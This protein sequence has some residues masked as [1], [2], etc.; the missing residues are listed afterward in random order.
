MKSFRRKVRSDAHHR[1]LQ[2]REGSHDLP[3]LKQ[4]STRRLQRTNL[5]DPLHFFFILFALSILTSHVSTALIV[6]PPSGASDF[7]Q[8]A[9]LVVST[10]DAPIDP[11]SKLEVMQWNLYERSLSEQF[12]FKQ[13]TDTVRKMFGKKYALFVAKEYIPGNEDNG[14][15]SSYD[16]VGMIEMGMA[17][18]PVNLRNYENRQSERDEDSQREIDL[19]EAQNDN[20]V[21]KNEALESTILESDKASTTAISIQQIGLRPRATVG[22]ICVKSTN[23]NKGIGKALLGKCEEIASDV[24]NE[25][26]LFV[27]VEPD[28]KN[29]LRFFERDGYSGFEDEGGVQM[30]NATVIRKRKATSRPHLVLGKTF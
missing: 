8:L 27:E 9:S 6:T 2:E 25:P 18:G 29:A 30:R 12:T 5:P 15:Q 3:R 17:L 20:S 24:W 19:F 22:V 10:F 23:H 14:F 13:Y 28:N 11:A 16:V 7:R 21:G 1:I 4:N 26:Q